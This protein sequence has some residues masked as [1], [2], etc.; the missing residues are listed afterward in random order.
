MK[1]RLLK[2]MGSGVE[3]RAELDQAMRL[4][5]EILPDD[6]RSEEQLSN[7]DF[8]IVVYYYSR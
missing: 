6:D 2:K 3:G 5:K 1:G 8:D 4:R 7:Y